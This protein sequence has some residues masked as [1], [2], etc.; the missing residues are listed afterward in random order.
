[1]SHCPFLEAYIGR[2]GNTAVEG[3]D[4]CEKHAEYRCWCGAQATHNCDVAVSLV[5]GA[6]LCDNHDCHYT[7]AGMTGTGAHS[8][9]GRQQYLEFTE[10]AS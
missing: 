3:S 6:P 4:F 7:G 2:C 10:A 9:K 1:M 5:C 8:T